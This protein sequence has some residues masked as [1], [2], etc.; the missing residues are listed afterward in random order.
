MAS[1]RDVAELAGVSTATVSHVIN[2]T[3]YVS[4]ELTERVQATLLELNYQPDAV[5]RSLRRRETLTIG[6]LIPNLEIPFFASVAYSIERAAAEHGYNIILCN[7]QWQ[8]EEESIHLQGLLARRVDGLICISAG[9]N[10]AEIAPFIDAGTPVVMFERQM[11]GIGLDAVGIDNAKGAY[12]AT[13]HLLDLGH[14]RIAA[15]TGKAI[16]TV[17]DRRLQGYRQA[18]EN[19]GLAFKPSYVYFGDYL[20]DSG[21]RAAKHFLSLPERPTA[22]FAFNDLMALGALQALR[23][24]GISVPEQ[25]AVVGFDGIVMSQFASPALTTMRQPLKRMGQT[26]VKLLMERIRGQGPEQAQYI[27][28][29]PE[30]IVRAS[31]ARQTLS[32]ADLHPEEIAHV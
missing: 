28:L 17:S 12:R 2:G 24:H 29:E 3:R 5:A 16:S 15:I 9:M 23:A 6:V 4:P 20:P 32:R 8:Q 26:A 1:I 30:L 7:S 14:R 31:S 27:E 10:A 18:L 13:K 21:S 11:P 25:M 19:A 22:I